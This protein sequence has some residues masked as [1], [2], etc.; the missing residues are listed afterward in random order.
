M[1]NNIKMPTIQIFMTLQDENDFS[2]SLLANFD[3]IKFIDS[4]VWDTDNPPFYDSIEKCHSRLNSQAVIINQDITSAKEY[5]DRY[6]GRHISSQGYIGSPVGK[7]LIQFLHSSKAEYA[8]NCLRNGRISA[9]YDP[10]KDPETEAFVKA[11][12]KI[13]KKGA[14]K[15]YLID[16]ETGEVNIKPE[17][18][19][20]AWPDAA[21]TYD[22]TDGR[23]LTNH[24]F[25]YF[26]AKP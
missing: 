23:Y 16:R 22:G 20:F 4:Y 19:F 18:N 13:F 21:K 15:V 8:E 6:T 3:D 25:A 12:W 17:T 2:S 9:T 24:A 11:V 14:K 5:K 10:T 1:S 7:G 26:V